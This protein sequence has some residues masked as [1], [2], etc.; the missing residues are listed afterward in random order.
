MTA[1]YADKTDA[2][3]RHAKIAELLRIFWICNDADTDGRWGWTRPQMAY[4]VCNPVMKAVRAMLHADFYIFDNADDLIEQVVEYLMDNTA[5]TEQQVTEAV[6]LADYK[7]SLTDTD[8]SVVD[9]IVSNATS[10]YL[11]TG[12]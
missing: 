1:S 3:I 8:T 2:Q 5:C 7:L 12:E 6:R 9:D 11:Q 10:Y 4:T